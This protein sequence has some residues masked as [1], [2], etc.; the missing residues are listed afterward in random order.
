MCS[1][2]GSPICIIARIMYRLAYGPYKSSD[3]VRFWVRVV[4]VLR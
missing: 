1:D 4:P 2:P 3:P